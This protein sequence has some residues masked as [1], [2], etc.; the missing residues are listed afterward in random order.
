MSSLPVW[1]AGFGFFQNIKFVHETFQT[2]SDPILFEDFLRSLPRL[3]ELAPRAPAGVRGAGRDWWAELREEFPWLTEDDFPDGVPARGHGRGHGDHGHDPPRPPERHVVGPD[4]TEEV[5]LDVKARLDARRKA[6]GHDFTDS[7]FYVRILGGN[8]T[9]VHTRS[10]ANAVSMYA[11]ECVKP[12]CTR[13]KMP[14]QKGF[15]HLKFTEDGA[16][17][18]AV[19]WARRCDFFLR[20]WVEAGSDPNFLYDDDM[21]Q[22]YVP[23]EEFLDYACALDVRTNQFDA[24]ME[25]NH[26]FPTNPA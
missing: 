14:K 25:L 21:K 17:I 6:W 22:S 7:W 24:V 11:R 4:I 16:N 15:H 12:W 26:A 20:L 9:F 10:D 19:A 5:A 2:R 3:P 13:Y 23:S 1:I 8:W 18:L